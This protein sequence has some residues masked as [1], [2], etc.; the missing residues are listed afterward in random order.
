MHGDQQDLHGNLQSPPAPI[1]ELA[2]IITTYIDGET[3]GISK[4]LVVHSLQ[5]TFAQ[6]KFKLQVH[7]IS[8]F[9]INTQ[10]TLCISGFHILG[11][12]Q[13]QMGNIVGNPRMWRVDYM[14]YSTPFSIR[15][16]STFGF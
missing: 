14:H 6:N 3:S 15:D 5:L 1:L 13:L 2:L 16:L 4:H 12:K 10:S 11:F 8:R 7:F 9:K